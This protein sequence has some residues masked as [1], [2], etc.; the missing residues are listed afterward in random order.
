MDRVRNT[1]VHGRAVIAREL[2]SKVDYRLLRWC[3][4]MERMNEYHVAI[5]VLMAEM[6]R[7]WVC[8]RLRLGLLDGV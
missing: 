1:K 7:R 5:R 3:G 2:V 8:G 6:I 4:R